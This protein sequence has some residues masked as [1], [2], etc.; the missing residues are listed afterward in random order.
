MEDLT[1]RKYG[2]WEVVSFSHKVSVKN[3]A[4]YYWNCRCE[5]GKEK[6]V[7]ANGLRSGASTSCG[8]YNKEIISI[9][10]K[11][12]MSKD[13][14]YW[15]W[16]SMI[17]RCVRKNNPG[18]KHYGGRGISVC[19]EWLDSKNFIEWALSNGYRKDLTIDRIDY[20]GNYEPSNCRWVDWKTQ[21]NNTSR[22]HYVTIDGETL[23]VAQWAER[24][25]IA[26]KTVFQRTRVLGWSFEK[27]LTV[28]VRK[29][30]KT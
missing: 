25:G 4:N 26:Y 21:A 12:G 30:V 10:K 6:V 8:C 28:P 11:H 15:I 27:A 23:T 14:L 29:L 5:C 24:N 13:R 17:D 20:N 7:L 9:P 3:G 1:G 19:E 22:N 16:H 2:R 18:Y